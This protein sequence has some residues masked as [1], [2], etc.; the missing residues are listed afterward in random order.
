MEE[1]MGFQE[2]RITIMPHLCDCGSGEES[3]ILYD[4]RSIPCGRVCSKCEEEK[5]S[6]YRPEIFTDGD[7]ECDEVVEP[8]DCY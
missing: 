2:E 4:A 5:K 6:Q 7:Y 3:Y 1:N 8:E